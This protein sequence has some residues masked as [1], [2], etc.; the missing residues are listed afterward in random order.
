[1]TWLQSNTRE[2]T[3]TRS[4]RSL[5]R[6]RS[7]GLAGPLAETPI[8]K[9]RALYD[10]NVF[11]LLAVTQAVAPGMVASRRGTIVNIASIVGQVGTPFAGAYSSSKAAVINASDVLRLELAPFGIKV[12]CVCPGA[13]RSHF[14]SNTAEKL[15]MSSYK[16]YASFRDAIAARATASQTVASTPA[17]ELAARVVREVLRPAPP[18]LLW[19]G[20]MSGLCRV[21]L[22]LPRWLRDVVLA[23]RFGLNV[24]VPPP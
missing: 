1:M 12:V 24:T 2:A 15:D 18:A 3:L 7:A 13:I 20:H 22:W 8:S 16:L 23:R 5:S 4:P 9:I 21:M 14:G 19:A 11:G 10:V 6:P 17:E